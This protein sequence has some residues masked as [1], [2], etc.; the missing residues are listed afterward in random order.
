MPTKGVSRKE[1]NKRIRQEALREQLQASGHH[2]RANKIINTLV[3]TEEEITPEMV[4][5]YKIALDGHFKFIHKYLGDDRYVQLAGDPE[6]PLF[7]GGL[8][9]EFIEPE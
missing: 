7:D 2:T 3:N 4:A 9:V 1:E 8:T 6:K 5:R